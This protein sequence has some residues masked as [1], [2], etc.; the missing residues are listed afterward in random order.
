MNALIAFLTAFIVAN[1]D[2][3]PA[4]IEPI[5]QYQDRET[6]W[7]MNHPGATFRPERQQY[8]ALYRNDFLYLHDQ[9]KAGD[10]HDVSILAHELVHHL[11]HHSDK[12]YACEKEKEAHAYHLQIEFLE[13]FGD[14]TTEE[15]FEVM[16]VNGVWLH[17]Q[18]VCPPPW[19][20][21]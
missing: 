20:A 10:L 12:V 7:H 14:M 17:Q 8:D 19:A 9:W 6:L 5:V 13:R 21:P 15:V 2:L 11:Q 16:G 3:P 18:T 4:P 1:S